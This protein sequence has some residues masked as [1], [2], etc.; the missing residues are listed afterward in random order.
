MKGPAQVS[1][2]Q[3]HPYTH[4]DIL[5][6]HV[7]NSAVNIQLFAWAIFNHILSACSAQIIK[8]KKRLSLILLSL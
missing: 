5:F 4:T 8:N 3:S 1:E 6:E 7:L 2:A